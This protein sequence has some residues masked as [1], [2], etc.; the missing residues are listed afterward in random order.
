MK[1]LHRRGGVLP[2]AGVRLLLQVSGSSLQVSG[3]S[4][5]VSG[6]SLTSLVPGG[7]HGV[8]LKADTWIE[9]RQTPPPPLQ[10]SGFSLTSSLTLQNNV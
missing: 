10:V 6:F 8:S 3:S 5:Q 9:G 2:G 7:V 1:F 4:L